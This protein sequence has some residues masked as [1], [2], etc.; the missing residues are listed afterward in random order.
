MP[1]CVVVVVKIQQHYGLQCAIRGRVV[2]RLKGGGLPYQGSNPNTFPYH[3]KLG[4]P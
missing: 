2:V 1:E 4:H 3:G